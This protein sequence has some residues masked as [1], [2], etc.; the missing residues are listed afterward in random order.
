MTKLFFYVYDRH[1]LKTFEKIKSASKKGFTLIE[2]IV[3]IAILGILAAVLITTIDPLDKINSAND[4]GVVSSIAQF[5][6]ANDSYAAT[7][8]NS[9]VG[10]ASP[11][12]NLALAALQTAGETKIASYTQPGGYPVP[13]YLKTPTTC[14]SA[15]L[16]CAGYAFIATGLKSKKNAAAPVYQYVNGR[17]CF[18]AAAITQVELDSLGSASTGAGA[19]P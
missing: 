6:K 1:T 2:L 5:G 17:G 11:T 16:D 15:L 8:N 10:M 13:T 7:H 4:A 19:C 3:V 9:Y 18:V 12:V 14:T